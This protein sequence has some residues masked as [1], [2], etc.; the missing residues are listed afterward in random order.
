MAFLDNM[1]TV[2]T[3]LFMLLSLAMVALG[4]YIIKKSSHKSYQPS[5][6]EPFAT[7]F[8]GGAVII[9]GLEMLFNNAYL[10]FTG[11]LMGT[12]H[13]AGASAFLL[14]FMVMGIATILGRQFLT[15]PFIPKATNQRLFRGGLMIF[16][17][18][19]MFFKLSETYWQLPDA[20]EDINFW[21]LFGLILWTGSKAS[22]IRKQLN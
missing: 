3:F 9:S 12:H 2:F 8:M 1:L 21:L 19:L 14:F 17:G 20:V 15:P 6:V 5:L 7:R 18:I 16:V 22:Q 10:L 4:I 13:L 11:K